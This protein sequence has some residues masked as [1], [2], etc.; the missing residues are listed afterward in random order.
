MTKIKLTYIGRRIAN[1][2]KVVLAFLEGKKEVY[3][4]KAKW[5]VIGR[6]YEGERTGKNLQMQ[7]RPEDLGESGASEEQI[8]KW[9]AQDAIAD[10]FIVRKRMA[11]KLKSN[12]FLTAN[13]GTLRSLCK[14]LS[15]SEKRTLLE[16]LLDELEVQ[17]EKRKYG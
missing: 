10:Q 16:F 3:F 17:T 1:D 15:F 14:G 2:D 5:L 8:E 13:L 7:H 11:T 4:V 12:K 9:H 6:V